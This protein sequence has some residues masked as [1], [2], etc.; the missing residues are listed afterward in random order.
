MSRYCDCSF[1]KI[2]NGIICLVM[3]IFQSTFSMFRLLKIYLSGSLTLKSFKII[4]YQVYE[5]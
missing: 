1:Q 3:I 5:S 2:K 4:T